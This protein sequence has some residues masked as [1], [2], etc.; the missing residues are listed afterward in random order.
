[1]MLIKSIEKLALIGLFI[2]SLFLVGC[3]D[4]SLERMNA[5]KITDSVKQS[6]AGGA[7]GYGHEILDA[8][9][10]VVHH[11]LRSPLKGLYRGYIR[12]LEGAIT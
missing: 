1:M 10:D 8:E 2:T 3:P 9:E 5:I 12:H 4:N 7:G 6:Y 11:G